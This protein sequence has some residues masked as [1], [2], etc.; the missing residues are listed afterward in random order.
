MVNILKAPEGVR[1]ALMGNEAIARGLVEAGV[2]VVSG[3]PGT[4]SS[5]VIMTLHEFGVGSEIYV[6]WAVNERVAFEVAYGASIGGARAAVTMKAPGASVALDPVVSSAYG[7]VEGGLMIL[8]ADDP[9][10]HTTQT[11]QDDRWLGFLAKLPVLSPSSP[12]EAKD[13]TV[14]SLDLSEEVKLPVILRTTTR[15]NHTVGDVVLGPVRSV[16]RASAVQR[17]LPRF[18]RAGM[19]WN[20]ERHKWLNNQLNRVEEAFERVSAIRNRVEGSGRVCVVTEGSAY[21]YVTE[22]LREVDSEIKVIKLVLLYPPPK[23]FLRETLSGCEKVLVI[24]ELDPYLEFVT[25][26]ILSEVDVNTVIYGKSSGHIP[27]EG[28]LNTKIVR[29]ALHSTILTERAAREVPRAAE[30]G[31]LIKVAPRPPPMCPGCPH[32]NMYV[33][34]LL[35]IAR[36]GYRRSEVPVF[37]DIGCYALGV[38]PPLE[39]IWTEHSMGASISMAMG[40]KVAG[41]DKPVVAV[42]GD[43]TFFHAGIQPLIEAIHKQVDV[44]VVIA[45]NSIVAMT[46]HQSTPAWS[47]LESGRRAKSIDIESLVKTVGVDHVEVVDPYDLDAMVKAFE[48]LLKKP[49]VRV[50]ISKHPCALVEARAGGLRVRHR[51]VEDRCT[52]CLACIRA[53]GCPAIYFDGSKAR[54]DIEDCLG[55]GLCA[56][57][58]PYKAIEVVSYG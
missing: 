24:E 36:A 26:N 48:R 23:K 22:V 52:G 41:Y 47:A 13:L 29:S 54:V 18:V 5:E 38:Q 12:Q 14:A 40:L 19:V 35:G 25:R 11:E 42:I 58:C 44:L 31:Q 33:A 57:F 16:K 45:D 53:T 2:S 30:L 28:E 46:G 50:L 43:S 39:A 10:P 34:L 6:E 20:Y 17:D 15:V 27:M 49:G 56:R 8:V 1:I 9:G 4:P 3:Y 51:V 37:G 32:R 21:N 55:C 7:G